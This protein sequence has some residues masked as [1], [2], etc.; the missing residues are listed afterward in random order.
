MSRSKPGRLMLKCAATG[1]IVTPYCSK[2]GCKTWINT[3]SM[4]CAAPT[5][6]ASLTGALLRRQMPD[7][8]GARP[9]PVLSR[10]HGARGEWSV[11]P[12]RSGTRLP[13]RLGP[14]GETAALWDTMACGH[15]AAPNANRER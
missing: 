14:V 9:A 12:Q 11:H 13:R 3:A 4:G 5:A 1:G 10:R 2:D 7:T 8:V 6:R 15:Y